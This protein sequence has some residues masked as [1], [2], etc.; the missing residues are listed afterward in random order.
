MKC[1]I[2]FLGGVGGG[3]WGG[4]NKKNIP[5]CCLLQFLVYTQQAKGEV[6][7]TLE[8]M[9]SDYPFNMPYSMYR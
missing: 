5:K 7:A 3:G 2:L 9:K 1:L 4:G 6:M 8:L